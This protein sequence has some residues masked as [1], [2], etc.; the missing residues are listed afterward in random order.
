VKNIETKEKPIVEA[1]LRETH[2]LLTHYWGDISR[3]RD[4][5]DNLVAVSV[6]YKIDTG[7]LSPVVKTRLGFSRR[8]TD[9]SEVVVDIGQQEFQFLQEI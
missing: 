2:H 4:A 1:C 7:G 6:T 3:I 8:Y 9:M 5:K